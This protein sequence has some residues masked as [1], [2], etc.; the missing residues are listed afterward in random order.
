M[1]NI[2]EQRKRD[3]LQRLTDSIMKAKEENKIVDRDK[4]ISMMIVQNAI[5]R[6]TAIEEIN[7]VMDFLE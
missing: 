5:S 3:R 6:K 1:A 4:L 2:R 7:A